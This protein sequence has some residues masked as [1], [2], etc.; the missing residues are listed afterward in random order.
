MADYADAESSFSSQVMWNAMSLSPPRPPSH[1]QQHH[2]HILHGHNNNNNNHQLQRQFQLSQKQQQKHDMA[3]HAH[4]TQN[5]SLMEVDDDNDTPSPASLSSP[6]S[7][8]LNTATSLNSSQPFFSPIKMKD[9]EDEDD[10]EDD[11]DSGSGSGSS[12]PLSSSASNLGNLTSE[13]ANNSMM[14]T[15]K[16]SKFRTRLYNCSHCGKTYKHH[17]CLTKHLWEHHELWNFTKKICRTKHQQVQM[18]EAAQVLADMI[19]WKRKSL[20]DK[21]VL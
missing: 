9:E 19:I 7:P 8:T 1:F 5:I 12:T 6:T 2:P 18:L 21:N 3:I 11:D 4:G 14:V 13:F 16:K 17:G 20:P 10:G 15:A